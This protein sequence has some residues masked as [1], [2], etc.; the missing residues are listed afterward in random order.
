MSIHETGLQ[1]ETL[2]DKV[3]LFSL[4]SSRYPAGLDEQ[5]VSQGFCQ[6]SI[7]SL[8]LQPDVFRHLPDGKQIFY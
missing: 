6:S 3:V 8:P 5:N 1:F 4:S 7:C 2:R